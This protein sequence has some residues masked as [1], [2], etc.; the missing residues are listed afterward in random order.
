MI[1]LLVELFLGFY[2]IGNGAIKI[3]KTHRRSIEQCFVVEKCK[4]PTIPDYKKPKNLNIIGSK[5]KCDVPAELIDILEFLTN[6]DWICRFSLIT[7]PDKN[8]APRLISILYRKKVMSRGEFYNFDQSLL[9]GDICGQKN[10]HNLWNKIF[11]TD[12]LDMSQE[13]GGIHCSKHGNIIWASIIRNTAE[14]NYLTTDN[15]SFDSMVNLIKTNLSSGGKYCKPCTNQ[16]IKKNI[17]PII[18]MIRRPGSSFD[19]KFGKEIHHSFSI[20]DPV[21]NDKDSKTDIGKHVES[22]RKVYKIIGIYGSSAASESPL[23]SD[24]AVKIEGQWFLRETPLDQ[25]KYT[26]ANIE[27]VLALFGQQTRSYNII[28]LY[29]YY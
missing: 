4:I 19:G 1:V 16:Y 14:L 3:H 13:P 20:D 26:E 22:S 24:I 23:R 28:L 11:Y 21:D 12:F 29:A 10:I 17:S 25:K 5:E 2:F 18:F 27:D 6:I 15:N 9:P 7:E 8:S